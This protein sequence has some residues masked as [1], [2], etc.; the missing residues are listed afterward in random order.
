M[1][2]T[3]AGSMGERGRTLVAPRSLPENQ[4][5]GPLHDLKRATLGSQGLLDQVR[6]P[7]MCGEQEWI[8]FNAV[9]F[10]NSINLLVGAVLDEFCSDESCPLMSAGTFKYAWAD[11]VNYVQPT[12]VSAPK[13]FELLLNWV[14]KQLADEDFLPVKQGVPFP[15]NFMKNMK[16][17]FKRL[18]RIYGHIFH[19][20]YRQLAEHDCETHLDHCFKH[21]AFFVMEFNM[22]EKEEL[23]PLKDVMAVYAE[24]M[25]KQRAQSGTGA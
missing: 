1:P 5:F 9:E 25:S 2:A 23:A 7:H 24:E 18:F 14:D 6:L 16:V 20:H 15:P 22:V 4:R 21:F 13:Y 10:F 17:I 11:G 3:V 8:A 19:S 12:T